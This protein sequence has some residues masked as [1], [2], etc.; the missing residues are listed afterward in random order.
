MGADEVIAMATN[1]PPMSTPYIFQPHPP[2]WT[3]FRGLY[4]CNFSRFKGVIWTKEDNNAEVLE[5]PW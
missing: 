3:L 2:A 5:H 4:F 1:P